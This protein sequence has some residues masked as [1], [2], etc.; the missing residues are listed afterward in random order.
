MQRKNP[1]KVEKILSKHTTSLL[2]T[3]T[4]NTI[5]KSLLRSNFLAQKFAVD[6]SY[7]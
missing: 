2:N 1:E 3:V 4:S 7:N 6:I 5:D